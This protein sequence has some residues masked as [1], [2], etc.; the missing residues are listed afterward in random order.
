MVS[1]WKLRYYQNIEDLKL[2]IRLSVIVD[3]YCNIVKIVSLVKYVKF[4]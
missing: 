3:D 1:L 2:N 4:K